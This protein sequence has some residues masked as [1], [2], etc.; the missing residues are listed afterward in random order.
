MNGKL[1]PGAISMGRPAEPALKMPE[2]AVGGPIQ[3]SVGD[4]ERLG[5]MLRKGREQRIAPASPAVSAP[6]VHHIGAAEIPD[7][8]GVAKAAAESLARALAPRWKAAQQSVLAGKGQDVS[9]AGADALLSR[10][11]LSIARLEA[12]QAENRGALVAE[13]ELSDFEEAEKFAAK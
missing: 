10:T 3:L 8:L 6:V 9:L 7:I 2:K 5:K 4:S 12:A 11:L 13:N 1:T